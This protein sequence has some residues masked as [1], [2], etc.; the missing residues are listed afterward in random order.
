MD[1]YIAC[2]DYIELIDSDKSYV[3][4]DARVKGYLQTIADAEAK[5]INDAIKSVGTV[6]VDDA[7]AIAQIKADKD[8][9]DQLVEDY[10]LIAP[11]TPITA[12]VNELLNDLSKAQIDEVVNAIA[13]MEMTM[14]AE[15]IAKIKELQAKYEALKTTQKAAVDKVDGAYDK[16]VAL[17]KLATKYEISSVESLKVVKNHSTAGR[18]NGKSWI[19]IMWSTQGD[20]SAVQGYEIYKSTKKNSGYKYAFTTKNPE[21]KWYKNTAGLKKGTMYYYKVRAFVEIDGAKYYS[22]WSNKAYR[23]AK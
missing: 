13:T 14:S 6:T 19:K 2:S 9:L 17:G 11:T 20:D 5:A 4:Y 3:L 7:D 8:A 16:Y 21:N 23:K 1:D 22:D 12:T 18:T 10:G 15:N